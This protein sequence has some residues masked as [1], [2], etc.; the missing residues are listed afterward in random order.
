MLFTWHPSI[1][2]RTLNFRKQDFKL[3]IPKEYDGNSQSK[4]Q[5]LTPTSPTSNLNP[6]L[7]PSVSS[8]SSNEKLIQLP[9]GSDLPMMTSPHSMI[10]TLLLPHRKPGLAFLWD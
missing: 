9:R 10:K 6:P 3:K 1:L 7:Y 4:F 8:F 5:L 2:F